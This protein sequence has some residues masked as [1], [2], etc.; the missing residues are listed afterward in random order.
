MIDFL[1]SLLEV[2]LDGQLV[3]SVAYL[4]EVDG[5]GLVEIPHYQPM[6]QPAGL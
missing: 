3:R 2:S 6:F 4:L 5:F 1:V